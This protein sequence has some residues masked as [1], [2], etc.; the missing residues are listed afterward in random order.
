MAHKPTSL[1]SVYRKLQKE[2]DAIEREREALKKGM[3]TK[4]ASMR[5]KWDESERLV[6]SA[7]TEACV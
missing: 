6:R 7:I 3:K 2:Q 1:T 5:R 4:F